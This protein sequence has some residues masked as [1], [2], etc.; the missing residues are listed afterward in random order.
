VHTVE[1]GLLL[2]R[3]AV[4]LKQTVLP[5][6]SLNVPTG[7]KMAEVAPELNTKLPGGALRQLLAPVTGL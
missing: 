7:H 4:Q 2:K 5:L 1:P 3:P 6:T